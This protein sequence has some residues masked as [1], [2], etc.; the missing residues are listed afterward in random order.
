MVAF[1][2]PLPLE[3]ESIE[4][5][6]EGEGRELSAGDQA[7]LSYTGFDGRTGHIMWDESPTLTE[8]HEISA[9]GVGRASS[10]RSTAS[11]RAAG[12]S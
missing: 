2:A 7:L 6:T 5:L 10:T 11:P 8:I 1:E 3:E 4:V 12:Y 9:E